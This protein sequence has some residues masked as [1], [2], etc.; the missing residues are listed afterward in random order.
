MVLIAFEDSEEESGGGTWM[1][2]CVQN[3][4]FDAMRCGVG[5]G[6]DDALEHRRYDATCI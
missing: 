5:H 3:V 4:W 2:K 6:G 1:Q